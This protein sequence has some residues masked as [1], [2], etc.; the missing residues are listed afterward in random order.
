MSVVIKRATTYAKPPFPPD[1][2]GRRSCSRKSPMLELQFHGKCTFSGSLPAPSRSPMSG[3][4]GSSPSAMSSEVE[5]PSTPMTSP[6]ARAGKDES[7]DR[8]AVDS[9]SYGPC[10]C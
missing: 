2:L 9:Q 8:F 7:C 1:Q 10:W 6:A 5:S 4:R 3:P